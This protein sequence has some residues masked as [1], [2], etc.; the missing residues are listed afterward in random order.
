MKGKHKATTMLTYPIGLYELFSELFN[1]V[2][3][4]PHDFYEVNIN[5]P[6]LCTK[7][8]CKIGC[9]VIQCRPEAKL[10]GMYNL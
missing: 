1:L 4:K 8:C 2:F 5:N 10:P 7:S 6:I 9:P 3:T